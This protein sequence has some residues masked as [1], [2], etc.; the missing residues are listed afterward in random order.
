MNHFQ[1]FMQSTVRYMSQ[2]VSRDG[3]NM[4]YISKKLT[5]DMGNLPYGWKI[6]VRNFGNFLPAKTCC[7]F[8]L[9]FC[10]CCCCCYEQFLYPVT[11][12]TENQL[13]L[14]RKHQADYK[15]LSQNMT[16]DHRLQSHCKI[17]SC[18]IFFLLCLKEIHKNLCS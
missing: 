9:C 8:C 4:H 16:Y 6:F 14:L 17:K 3:M 1:I 11:G 2:K 12:L 18:E 5:T 7:C 13:T 10:F 15:L